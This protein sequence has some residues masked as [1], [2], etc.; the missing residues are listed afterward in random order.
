[1]CRNKKGVISDNC[2]INLLEIFKKLY[3]A[4]KFFKMLFQ[5]PVFNISKKLEVS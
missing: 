5:I 2:N 3:L 4:T 1:M